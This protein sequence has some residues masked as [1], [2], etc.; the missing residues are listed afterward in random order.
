M[1]FPRDT[2]RVLVCSLPVIPVFMKLVFGV[3]CFLK[4]S[5]DP[6]SSCCVMTVCTPEELFRLKSTF[7]FLLWQLFL[8]IPPLELNSKWNFA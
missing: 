5:S 1:A 8:E 4:L 2:M 7:S 6:P 3:S